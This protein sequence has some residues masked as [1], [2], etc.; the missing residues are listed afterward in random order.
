MTASPMK[1]RNNGAFT[2][3]LR[4]KVDHFLV[5]HPRLLRQARRELAVKAVTAALLIVGSYLRYSSFISA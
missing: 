1:F 4:N 5:Q 3:D 2:S